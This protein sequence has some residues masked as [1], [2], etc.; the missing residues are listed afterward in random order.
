ML[1]STAGL[2]LAVL[3]IL[4]SRVTGFDKDRSFFPLILIVIA[5]Y[6]VL[7]AF[8]EFELFTALFEIT[9]AL[10]F[11]V[12]AIIGHNKSIRMVGIALI[13]QG[14]YDLF[15]SQIP[16]A[17]F[18]PQWWP[19]FCSAVDLVIGL[20]VILYKPRTETKYPIQY[21]LNLP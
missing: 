15:H 3:I 4:L 2:I 5:T 6:Y 9:V 21:L 14:V 17:G 10:L 19:L 8:Q 18:A 13:A 11:T 20:W 16:V 12:F 7:F 1:E